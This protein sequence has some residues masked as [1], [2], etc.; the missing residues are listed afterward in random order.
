LRSGKEHRSLR[1]SPSQPELVEP[2]GVAPYLI[3]REDTSKTNEGGLNHCKKSAKEVV[4]Y[5]KL[6]DPRKCLVNLYNSK[7]SRDRPKNAFY[8]KPLKKSR[9]DCWYQNVAVGQNSLSSTVKRLCQQGGFSGY[10]TNHSLQTTAAT[11]MFEARVDEQ[12]IMQRTGHATTADV[13][14]YKRVGEKLKTLTSDALN[15]AKLPKLDMEPAS[16]KKLPVSTESGTKA[17]AVEK[18]KEDLPHLPS[19]TFSGASNF[20]VNLTFSEWKN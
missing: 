13:W 5:A 15:G 19:L 4:H 20:T 1:H 17:V 18:E 7:C 12:L 10:F 14:C 2:P 16:P 3:Y 9:S 8:L 11:R 6:L